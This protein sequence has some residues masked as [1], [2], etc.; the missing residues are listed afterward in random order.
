MVI[1]TDRYHLPMHGHTWPWAFSGTSTFQPNP[2]VEHQIQ[3]A[4]IFPKDT[5]DLVKSKVKLDLQ[6][7]RYIVVKFRHQDLFDHVRRL[8]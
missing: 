4:T 5:T 2:R 1:R 8:R 7:G 3:L 6:L